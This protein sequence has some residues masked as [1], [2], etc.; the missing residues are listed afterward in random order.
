MIE[1]LLV[2]PL[3]LL[4]QTGGQPSGTVQAGLLA[5]ELVGAVLGV[6]IAYLAYRGYRRNQS[7]PMLFVSLGF[8][9]ALGVPLVITLVYIALPITGGRVAVQAVNQTFEIVGLVS[10]LYGLR[11]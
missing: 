1:P 4:L 11:V 3:T 7:R 10:I 2:S 8:I 5:Y 9:L 6:G